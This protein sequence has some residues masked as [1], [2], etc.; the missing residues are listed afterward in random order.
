M[1]IQFWFLPLIAFLGIASNLAFSTDWG[2]SLIGNPSTIVIRILQTASLLAASFVPLYSYY[3]AE[4]RA[5]TAQEA[6]AKREAV[7]CLR[8]KLTAAIG[9]LFQNENSRR[10]RAN[11]MTVCD[12]SLRILC[13]V[14]MD[15]YPDE[16]L[17]LAYGQGCAGVAWQRACERPMSD[18]WVPIVAPNA[19]ITPNYL[20]EEWGLDADRINSTAH[21]LWVLSTPLFYRQEGESRFVG[22]LNFDGVQAPLNAPERLE[23]PQLHKDVADV[24]DFFAKDLVSAQLA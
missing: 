9:R 21:V 22:T 24:A 11:I 20:R 16:N 13:S 2:R 7:E 3:R 23:D 14:N 19:L 10:I 12:D 15:L 6:Q 18:R 4:K 17:T 8:G 5:S 1:N